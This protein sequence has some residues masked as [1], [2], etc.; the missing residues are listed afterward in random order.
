MATPERQI[1]PK[2]SSKDTESSA[3]DTVDER[4]NELEARL[5]RVREGGGQKPGSKSSTLRAK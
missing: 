3:S 2:P 5:A 4:L 1:D